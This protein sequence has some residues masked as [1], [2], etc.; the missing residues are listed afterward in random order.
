LPTGL[1]FLSLPFAPAEIETLIDN[2]LPALRLVR[3]R[4][5]S[6]YTVHTTDGEKEL[7]QWPDRRERFYF[8]DYLEQLNCEELRFLY[9]KYSEPWGW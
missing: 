4:D 8:D 6:F 3:L 9:P 2:S 1:K 5:G 7:E